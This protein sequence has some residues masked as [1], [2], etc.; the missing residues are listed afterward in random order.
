MRHSFAKY[1]LTYFA[2]L[3]LPLLAGCDDGDYESINSPKELDGFIRSAQMNG[4]KNRWN[5]IE[6][7][8]RLTVE[9][10]A[11]FRE[12][13]TTG[14]G[15]HVLFRS[16]SPVDP[17]IGRSHYADSLAKEAGI[18]GFINLADTQMDLD[19]SPDF[20]KTYYST[21]KYVC[22]QMTMDFM[23]QTNRERIA[24]AI[25][26]IMGNDGPYLIH[27]VEGKDRTGFLVAVLE[28]LM[29]ATLDEI[30]ADYVKSF[31]NFYNAP[32]GI[33]IPL[34]D[35]EKGWFAD[36]VVENLKIA[37]ELESLDKVSLSDA[38]FSYLRRIGFSEQEISRLRYHLKANRGR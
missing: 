6:A 12:V 28:A 25:Y 27:C 11:N 3:L 29:G 5:S 22:A 15:E 35:E 36:V 34:T 31:S 20:K 1:F 10:Y 13:T 33:Q 24:W 32:N 16:S 30:K 38:A 2:M 17:S 14:M 7:Y 21:Q 18:K 8:P 19:S 26:F 37:F 23:S 4:L 9:E